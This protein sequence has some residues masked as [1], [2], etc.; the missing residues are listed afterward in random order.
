MIVGCKAAL[1]YLSAVIIVEGPARFLRP[2]FASLHVG[3]VVLGRPLLI[4][5]GARQH[6]QDGHSEA[7]HRQRGAPVVREERQAYVTVGVDMVVHGHRTHERHLR[8]T[9]RVVVAEHELKLEGVASV[10][11]DRRALD[12]HQP[13]AH[14]VGAV[15]PHAVRRLG[16]QGLDLLRQPPRAGHRLRADR[17]GLL[18]VHSSFVPAENKRRACWAPAG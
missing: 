18:T 5:C 10:D 2:P 14:I 3:A 12:V 4:V 7:G 6:R 17:L 8:R 13:A 1:F 16:L 15:Q 11:A 9:H